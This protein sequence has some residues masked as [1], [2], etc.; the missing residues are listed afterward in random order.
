MRLWLLAA[1]VYLVLFAAS[2]RADVTQLDL[3][4]AARALSFMERPLSGDVRLG[5]VFAPGDNDSIRSAD[6]VVKLLGGGMKVGDVTFKPVAVNIHQAKSASVDAFFLPDGMGAL[7]TEVAAATEEKKVPCITLDVTQVEAGTCVLGL[8]LLP[9]VQ[10]YINRSAAASSNT[11][12]VSVF[13]MMV[14]EF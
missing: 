5:I 11:M 13:R 4:I 2:A 6:A 7:A 9:K 1:G 14:T 10:I 12:F 3:Q 8:R